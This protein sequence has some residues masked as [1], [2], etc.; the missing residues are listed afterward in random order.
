MLTSNDGQYTQLAVFKHLGEAQ[1]C[2]RV[3]HISGILSSLLETQTH[4]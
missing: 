2:G 4:I 3:K 1:Q